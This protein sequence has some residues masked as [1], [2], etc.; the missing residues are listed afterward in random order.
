MPSSAGDARAVVYLDVDGA[1]SAL[2]GT[3]GFGDGTPLDL[4]GDV[5]TVSAGLGTRLRA[6]DAELRW[7]TTWGVDADRI[8]AAMGLPPLLVAEEP[9]MDASAGGPWKF[10]AVRAQ[11]E[12]ERRP[13]VWV[14]DEAIPDD[15]DGWLASLDVPGLLVRPDPDLGLSP[16]DLY[17]VDAFLASLTL[18]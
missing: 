17:A 12:R 18:P 11:V 3:H 5:L 7:L 2:S 15:A 16:A 14:D 10:V 6:L 4:Y 9:P 13:F 1:V 8:G